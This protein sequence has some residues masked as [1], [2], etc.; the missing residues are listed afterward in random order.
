MAK[1]KTVIVGASDNPARYAQ[2][3]LQMLKEYEHPIVPIGIHGGQFQG[4]SILDMKAKPDI[5]DV[6][7][8]T[9]YL[10]PRN[11]PEW[12]DYFLSL[13]PKRIIFNPGTE[14]RELMEKAKEKGIEPVIGCT[15][16]M[17]RSG[18]F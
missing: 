17:L 11:Q 14:N 15:L 6:D 16:V 13:N 10:S 4:E 3:A 18:Q 7:T 5:A 2:I 1:K 9:L 12:Y 8:I